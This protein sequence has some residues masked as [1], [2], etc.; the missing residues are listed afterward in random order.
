VAVNN[1]NEIVV[2]DFHNHSVK[3]SILPPS[4]HDH[5]PDV[6]TSSTRL[7]SP[8]PPPRPKSFIEP[9]NILGMATLS[10]ALC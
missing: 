9:I 1:K 7:L 3:V 10:Q 2:T 6:P 8:S 5:C 4:L